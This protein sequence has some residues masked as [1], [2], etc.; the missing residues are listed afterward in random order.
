MARKR[1]QPD[2]TEKSAGNQVRHPI[3]AANLLY[4]APGI[5][6]RGPIYVMFLTMISLLIYSF[7]AKQD[8]LVAAPLALQRQVV[9]VQAIGGGLVESL[10]VQENSV[11]NAG[12]MLAVIQE[13]IRAAATP[14]QEAILD[15]I[16]NLQERQEAMLKD[17]DHQIRQLELD[18]QN[19]AERRRT[20]RDALDD[21]I[22]QIEIQVE[23]ARRNKA[24]IEQDL[25]VARQDL[26]RMETLFRNR[27]IT[28]PQ[29]QAAQDR[30]SDLQRAVSNAEAEV[31]RLM[32]SLDT[33]R[34]ERAQLDEEYSEERLLNDIENL[35]RD[36]ERDL[37]LS[38]ERITA[39]QGRLQAAQTLVP[40]VRYDQ[41]KAFYTSLVD[42]IVTTV[43]VQRGAIIN[44]GAPIV[45]IVRNTAPLEA[46]VLVQN[47]DIGKLKVGQTVQIKYFAYP[48]QEYGIQ[49][50][51]ISQISTKPN[52]QSFYVV[53]VA[54]ERETIRGRSGPDKNLEIGLE[55]IAEIKTGEKRFIELVFAPASR[56][57]QGAAE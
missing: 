19:L 21:R 41:D 56:F 13:K 31:Q 32:L 27:D 54:L 12:D 18:L 22:R 26:R 15:E 48:Y 8:E 17:Y 34:R 33:A 46:R 39:L 14:E 4:S 53:N 49:Q 52:E 11:V 10:Q 37:R 9:S 6:L 7:V 36:R 23:T 1:S 25:A 38:Q 3:K 16:R 35:K 57:F 5:V 45:S 20:D 55:G 47:K 2:K 29:F 24:G 50:G 51:W 42:G 30:V 43:H 44:P 40:G 28:Q